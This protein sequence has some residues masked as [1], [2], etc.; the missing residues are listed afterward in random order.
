MEKC[1]TINL[2]IESR[3]KTVDQWYQ[4]FAFVKLLNKNIKIYQCLHWNGVYLPVC[5]CKKISYQ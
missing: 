5:D 3:I 4:A 1:N 2:K